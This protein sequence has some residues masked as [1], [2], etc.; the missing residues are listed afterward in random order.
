MMVQGTEFTKKERFT[1]Y[2][3]VMFRSAIERWTSHGP[4]LDV[5]YDDVWTSVLMSTSVCVIFVSLFDFYFIMTLII[6]ILALI[7]VRTPH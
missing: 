5:S 1:N 7:K 2:F 6:L 3:N 4:K